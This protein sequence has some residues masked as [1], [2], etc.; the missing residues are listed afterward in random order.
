MVSELRGPT[1]FLPFTASQRP[2]DRPLLA[3]LHAPRARSHLSPVGIWNGRSFHAV[4]AC[5]T[6]AQPDMRGLL[7]GPGTGPGTGVHAAFLHLVTANVGNETEL[8]M[9]NLK[10]TYRR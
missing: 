3:G 10:K 4:H 6:K 2:P 7:M 8:K 1:I 5:V 9:C